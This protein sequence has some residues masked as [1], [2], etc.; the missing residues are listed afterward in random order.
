[1]GPRRG[2]RRSAVVRT[3]AGTDHDDL[4][5]LESSVIARSAWSARSAS[6]KVVGLVSL[7]TVSVPS[8]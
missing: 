3:A 7:M 4:V 1:M 5:G 8:P 6:T 2:A